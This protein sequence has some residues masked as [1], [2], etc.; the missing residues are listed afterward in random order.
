M[1]TCKRRVSSEP[2][3]HRHTRQSECMARSWTMQ[4]AATTTTGS[5][6]HD[7]H[8]HNER[9]V[10]LSH[11]Q[12]TLL[13]STQ[14]SNQPSGSNTAATTQRP[15]ADPSTPTSHASVPMNV[16]PGASASVQHHHYAPPSCPP[17]NTAAAQRR[18]GIPAAQT[19]ANTACK[20]AQAPAQQPPCM[21]APSLTQAPAPPQQILQAASMRPYGMQPTAAPQQ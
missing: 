14:H 19:Q 20:Q 8:A 7:L 21:V 12:D 13:T 10:T 17:A 9:S 5:P 4:V 15:Q 1:R 6:T 2:F 16:Q 3:R 18:T 11:V